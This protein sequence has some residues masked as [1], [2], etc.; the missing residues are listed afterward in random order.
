VGGGVV[1][2]YTAIADGRGTDDCNGHGT[3]VAGTVGG[4]T[5]GVAKSAKLSPVRVLDCNGSG[6]WSGVIAGVDWVTKNHTKPAVAN[7]SLG[8]GANT[9]VDNAVRNSVAAGVTYAVAAGNGNQAG[10]AQD[11]CKYSPARVAEALTVGAT[12][13]TDAKTSWSNYGDCVQLFAPGAGITSAWNTST[14][15]TRTISGTSMATPHVTGVAALYLE[16]NSTAAAQVVG[17][18]VLATSTKNVVTSSRTANNQLV[19]SLLD[20]GG[21]TE[22]APP[23]ASFTYACDGLICSFT[24]TSTDSDGTIGAWAWAFGDGKTSTIQNPTNT[25]GATGTY[26]VSLR[27]TDDGGAT[28]DTSRSVTV[29]GTPGSSTVQLAG[30]SYQLNRNFWRAR[31]TATT[32]PAVALAGTFEPGGSGSCTTDSAGSCGIGSGNLSNSKVSSTT[33]TLSGGW[34]CEPSSCQVTI[35]RP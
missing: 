15:A 27:V 13:N 3:H 22:N 7:M 2:G 28:A 11:A 9:A 33:F 20:A 31:V 32:S 26:T 14:T 29:A 6:T 25:Y 12:T 24:D 8:G 21:G 34:T 23:T 19:Y 1:A 30:S 35:P 5:Y 18:A 10:V 4:V 17:D 16:K